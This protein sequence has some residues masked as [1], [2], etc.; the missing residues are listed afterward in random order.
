M[1]WDPAREAEND[2]L[3]IETE[4]RPGKSGIPDTVVDA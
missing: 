3:P 4:T 2:A 1:R